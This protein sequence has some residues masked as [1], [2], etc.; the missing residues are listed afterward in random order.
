MGIFD[1]DL[2]RSLDLAENNYLQVLLTSFSLSRRG[3][4]AELYL[5][6]DSKTPAIWLRQA[7]SY[8]HQEICKSPE[9]IKKYKQALDGFLISSEGTDYQFHDPEYPFRYGSGGTLPVI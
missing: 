4:G 3:V 6:F 8:L 7:K 2:I 5:R 9:K 1:S